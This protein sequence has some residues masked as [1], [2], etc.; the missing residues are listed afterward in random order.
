ML[1]RERRETTDRRERDRDRD[2]EAGVRGRGNDE[3]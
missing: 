2:T 3:K 1:V